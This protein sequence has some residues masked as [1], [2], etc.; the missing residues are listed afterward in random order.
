MA[1]RKVQ[2][3]DPVEGL[4][5]MLVADTIEEGNVTFMTHCAETFES[6]AKALRDAIL[7]KE[8]ARKRKKKGE[9]R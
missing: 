7:K 6:M 5:T 1:K 2:D 3:D 8:T 9:R 4:L